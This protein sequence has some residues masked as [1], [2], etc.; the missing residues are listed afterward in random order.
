MTRKQ[1]AAILNVATELEHRV[2]QLESDLSNEINPQR[3]L[4][5]REEIHEFSGMVEELENTLE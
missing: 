4:E 5:L 1:R 3:R 2:Q